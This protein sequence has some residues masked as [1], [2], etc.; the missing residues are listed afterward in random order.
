MPNHCSNKTYILGPASEIDAIYAIIHNLDEEGPG[1]KY[2][3]PCPEDLVQT[4]AAS[5]EIPEIWNEY[6]EHAEW[7]IEKYQ[8]EVQAKKDLKQKQIEN[9]EKYGYKDWYDWSLAKYGTKWGDYDVRIDVNQ[10][11]ELKE[12]TVTYNTAWSPFEAVFFEEVSKKFPNCFFTTT[13]NETG[14]NFVGASIA[15]NGVADIESVEI[16]FDYSSYDDSTNEGFD[17]MMNALNDCIDMQSEEI[18][19]EL[20]SNFNSE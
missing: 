16:D 4:T 9:V 8:I 14:M 20:L 2:L 19:N 1:L 11:D 18:L 12:I 13:F 6:L 15:K 5:A 17:E 3:L 10:F 7:S